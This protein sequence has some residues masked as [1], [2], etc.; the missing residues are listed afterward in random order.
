MRS[1]EV[2]SYGPLLVL[3]STLVAAA[4]A[5]CGGSGGGRQVDDATPDSI[6]SDAEVE[7]ESDT[8][9]TTSDSGPDAT[10]IG[11]YFPP[12]GGGAWEAA[13]LVAT[14]WEP[15]GLEALAQVAE[16]NRSSSIIV[17]SEGRIVLERY[18]RGANADTQT[19]VAS[20]QKSVTSTLVGLAR[21]RGLLDL[22]DTV[23]T[24]LAAGWSNAS[25]TDEAAITIRNITTHSSGL[26]P[27]NLTQVAP[28]GTV[29]DYNTEAYQ[30]LRP[31]LEQVAGTDINALSRAWLFDAIGVTGT[32]VDRGIVDSTGAPIIGLRLSAR[33]MARIGLFAQR[34]GV[35]AGEQITSAGWYA[36]AW[37]PAATKDD[38]GLLWW[39][40]GRGRLEGKA[41]QDLVAALGAADQKIYISPS[42]KIVVTRQ[43]L[44]AGA[45]TE[46]E[47]DFDLV[48]LKAVADARAAP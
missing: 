4:L 40:Q 1:L 32:W 26:S 33:D 19:D 38:Y 9:E 44:A 10:I 6:A 23:S 14:G 28:R 5:S 30:K 39:L 43:G 34:F 13:D 37:T 35:W 46:A 25:P 31:I 41:P 2:H 17:L 3:S 36:E 29:F 22:D 12:L 47:S 20:V 27:Q 21:D 48:L 11:D 15:S 18:F 24:Y 7:T 45:A 16:D 42:L 8:A